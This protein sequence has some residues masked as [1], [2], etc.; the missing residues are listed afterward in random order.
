[1]WLP[2]NCGI[3]VDYVFRVYYS[4]FCREYHTNITTCLSSSVHYGKNE[5]TEIGD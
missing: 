5:F 4:D 2:P 1:M 3:C